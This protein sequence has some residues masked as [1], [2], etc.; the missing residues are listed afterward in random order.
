MYLLFDIGGTNMRLAIS[1]DGKDLGAQTLIP[2]PR[3]YEEGIDQFIRIARKLSG[4]GIFRAAAGGLATPMD[5]EH[6]VVGRAPNLPEWRGKSIKKDLEALLGVPVHIENDAAMGG[7]GEAT[8]GAGRGHEIVAYLTIGTGVGGARIVNGK[9]DQNAL[10]FEPGHQI[11]EIDGAECVGC[12][13]RGHLEAYVSGTGI[14]RRYNTNAE[15]LHDE[16]AWKEIAR[17]LAVGINNVLVHWSPDIVILGGSV[18]ET[19]PLGYMQEHLAKNVTIFPVIPPVKKAELK[20][21]VALHGALAYLNAL[22][23]K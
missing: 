6:T 17:Y 19:L 23:K 10:G 4:T 16:K 21:M 3:T 9:I 12:G 2:T 7:L 20:T 1:Q 15:D 11:I 14:Q 18:M 8:A 22:D 5:P 13:V